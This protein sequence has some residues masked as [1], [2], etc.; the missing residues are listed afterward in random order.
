M[1]KSELYKLAQ[2]AVLK[3]ADI[4]PQDKLDL[5]DIL[6]SEIYVAKLVE[7]KKGA[8]NDAKI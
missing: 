3:D 6:S 2:I 7:K 4:T 8:V 5:L 1:K